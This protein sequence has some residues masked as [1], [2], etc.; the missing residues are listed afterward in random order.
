MNKLYTTLLAG[1]LLV[2]VAGAGS[3]AT[4]SFNFFE[5][6]G[7]PTAFTYAQVSGNTYSL[8][9]TTPETSIIFSGPAAGAYANTP[10]QA[11]LSVSIVESQGDAFSAHQQELVDSVTYTFTGTS[12]IFTGKTFT[13]TAGDGIPGGGTA[14]ILSAAIGASTGGIA[15][16]NVL[17]SGVPST[18]V[19]DNVMFSSSAFSTTGWTFQNYSLTLTLPTG[20]AFSYTPQGLFLPNN[21]DPF[22]ASLTGGGVA[23]TP[24]ST[25]EPGSM[26]LAVGALVSFG[27]LRTRRRK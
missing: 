15:G 18:S 19:P 1:S 12:G 4:F 5:T 10:F 23:T 20:S 25:P 11:N 21:L 16:S 22:I 6:D 27:A 2:G 17:N 7:I 14:G 3:A 26:A 9:G 24:T 8:T 13:V